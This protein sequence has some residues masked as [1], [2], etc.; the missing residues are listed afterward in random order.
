MGL[1]LTIRLIA[2]SGGVKMITRPQTP[3]LTASHASGYQISLLSGY[4]S[5]K[6]CNLLHSSMMQPLASGTI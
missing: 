6:S 5:K 3:F 4:F 2:P 1:G